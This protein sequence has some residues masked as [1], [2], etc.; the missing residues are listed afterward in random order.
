LLIAG[1]HPEST[2]AG[3]ERAPGEADLARLL[4]GFAPL[5]EH[6][7]WTRS[8]VK[9]AAVVTLGKD[10]PPGLQDALRLTFA[11]LDKSRTMSFSAARF[12][13]STQAE[14]FL[15]GFH[16]AILQQQEEQASSPVA[17]IWLHH[18]SK[19][20]G[21]D[22]TLDG[23][24][25]DWVVETFGPPVL[26][27]FQHFHVE[28]L[29]VSVVLIGCS[30]VSR[31]TQDAFIAHALRRRTDPAAQPPPSP[32]LRVPTR[33]VT[34]LLLDPTGE[35]VASVDATAHAASSQGAGPVVRIRDRGTMLLPK[36]PVK[37]RA[38]NA[39]GRDGRPLQLLAD[40]IILDPQQTEVTV[41]FARGEPCQIQVV[42]PDGSA[43][44]GAQVRTLSR[45]LRQEPR[46]E[47]RFAGE[48]VPQEE[49]VPPVGDGKGTTDA[50]GEIRL[51][52]DPQHGSKIVVDAG[53]DFFPALEA[54]AP[55]MTSET[56]RLRPAWMLH[57]AVQDRDGTPVEDDV[58]IRVQGK[59]RWQ[60][61]D[62]AGRAEIGPLP[63]ETVH[64]RVSDDDLAGEVWTE[65]NPS[66]NPVVLTLAGRL[67]RLQ[68]L[69]STG[70][71]VPKYWV[72][73]TCNLSAGYRA[74]GSAGEGRTT[75]IV[76]AGSCSVEVREA[77]DADGRPLNLAAAGA[78]ASPE[79]R[80]LTLR[81]QPGTKM[82][83]TVRTA[84]GR[85]VAHAELFAHRHYDVYARAKTDADGRYEL[86]GLD[87]RAVKV[88]VR[89][90]EGLASPRPREVVPSSAGPSVDFTLPE[91]VPIT[92]IDWRG[93]RVGGAWVR[94][95]LIGDGPEAG[96]YPIEDHTNRDG[97]AYLANLYPDQE[98]EVMPQNS[99]DL[100]SLRQRWDGSPLAVRLERAHT[101]QVRVVDGSGPVTGAYIDIEGG[102]DLAHDTGPEGRTDV[103][104]PY[105]PMRLRAQRNAS[106]PWSEWV[107]V[108]PRESEV[109]VRIPD[110]GR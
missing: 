12:E 109:E 2:W 91:V 22:G 14:A 32:E 68:V 39:T 61:T 36:E 65:V 98:L 97:V 69:D 33:E 53:E 56:I 48:S 94:V 76:P 43:I 21:K 41:T 100:A 34:F 92:V 103:V 87:E 26:F 105:R 59:T 46:L 52:V 19:G 88:E 58:E 20:A 5:A 86:V 70:A 101:V 75:L 31:E 82:T 85:P 79:A 55:G 106:A 83:G 11:A 63:R 37:V 16:E 72:E 23:H 93:R 64:V 51:P 71:S 80:E 3:E 24:A 62:A 8:E 66:R 77:K 99:K 38:G 54:V 35:P 84:D 49:R 18:V 13:S 17:S 7:Q 78:S 29:F 15:A 108:G 102:E 30:H 40:E 60:K 28:Q 89:P 95:K 107:K 67:L 73:V 96:T 42:G 47:V 90:P 45:R 44:P 104:V 10:R 27:T 6:G 57:L 81:M 1:S 50:G 4:E 25:I 110:A 9:G 74:R